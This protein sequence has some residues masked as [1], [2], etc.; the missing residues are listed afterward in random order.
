MP[1]EW[2]PEAIEAALSAEVD[3]ACGTEEENMRRVL[4]AAVKAQ[5]LEEFKKDYRGCTN[6]IRK[7]GWNDAIEAAA[8]AA[9]SAEL[10]D[11]D[12]LKNSDP[13]KTIEAAIRALAKSEKQT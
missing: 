1:I 5:G 2:T 9:R 13:R 8:K 11:G 4:D 7:K 6:L 12:K 3:V 10:F